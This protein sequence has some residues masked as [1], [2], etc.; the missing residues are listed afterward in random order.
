MSSGRICHCVILFARLVFAVLHAGATA[1]FG[2]WLDADWRGLP[3]LARALGNRACKLGHHLTRPRIAGE[4]Q[5]V[6]QA[7]SLGSSA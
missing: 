1:M 5:F 3:A 4:F 2:N 6:I 7:A